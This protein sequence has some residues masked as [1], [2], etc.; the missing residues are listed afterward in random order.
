[1]KCGRN[2]CGNTAKGKGRFKAVTVRD[3]RNRRP[4]EYT[5]VW[6]LE[7]VG[8]F[9]PHKFYLVYYEH[10]KRLLMKRVEKPIEDQ[11][12]ERAQADI[13]APIVEAPKPAPNRADPNAI[14]V[15]RAARKAALPKTDQAPIA[16]A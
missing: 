4:K 13:L 3:E 1:M 10:N 12:V 6:C 11:K 16:G 8:S 5:E 9:Q 2:G 7:C 15:A 14:K